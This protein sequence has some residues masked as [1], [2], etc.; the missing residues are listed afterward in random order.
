VKSPLVSVII[1]TKN[2]E[3][4]LER[5]LVSV[6]KQSYSQIEIIVVDNNST[7]GT[8]LIAKK[9]TR[10]VLNFGPERSAQRNYGAKMA[11]G[12]YLLFLDADMELSKYI[13]K[14]CVEKIEESNLIGAVAVPER[15][16]AKTFWEKVKAFERS[17]YNEHGDSATDA[18][19]F[20]SKKVFKEVGGY[21]ESIT[22]PEDWDLPERIVSGGY[23]QVRIESKIH[24]YER[25]PN[26]I[27]LAMKKYYYG[28]K[29][30]RY[31]S[32]HK[33]SVFGPKSIY[34]LRP[35]FYQNW[36]KLIKHPFLT[37][38]MLVMLTF[39]Q[40]GGGIGYLIGKI[41]RI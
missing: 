14:E 30:H 32:K 34:V 28:L 12:E 19:R 8:K 17:L 16:I 9:Y 7:D 1:T 4:V 2:E 27:K 31:F 22:G 3:S 26:P 35:V 23:K 11:A 13:V 36:K 18:A 21:D 6:A 37:F 41:K 38:A 25:V 33:I 39:E 15:S 5:L 40:V 10:K 24:H 20:F 29:S